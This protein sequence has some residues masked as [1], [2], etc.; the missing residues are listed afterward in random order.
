MQITRKKNKYLLVSI[1]SIA[2]LMLGSHLWLQQ[3]IVDYQTSKPIVRLSQPQT[4]PT[5]IF[6]YK[7]NCPACQR[8]FKTVYLE[9]FL[10]RKN[11]QIV[12][13]N[14]VENRHYISEFDLHEVPTFI[15]Y[16]FGQETNRY[17]GI[18]KRE[19]QEVIN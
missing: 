3:K 17:S 10:K 14:Q 1:I 15:H 18:N 13:L 9:K 7:D 5:T 2:L 16:E 19:I 4:E 6:F 11:I 8:I 12:N